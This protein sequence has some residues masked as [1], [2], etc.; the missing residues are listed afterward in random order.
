MRTLNRRLFL[1]SA[2]AGFVRVAEPQSEIPEAVRNL[3][4][5]TAG[6]QPIDDEERQ[7]RIEKAQRLMREHRIGAVVMEVGSS[8]F[9]FTGR[10]FAASANAY[11]VLPGRGEPAWVV[12]PAGDDAP[13]TNARE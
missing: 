10:R 7:A 1:V 2:A 6:I 13:T 4:P 11:L 8:M 5:M 9:Y 3:R 12:P